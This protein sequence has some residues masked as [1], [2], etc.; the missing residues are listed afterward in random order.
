V[1][2]PA[3]YGE[4]L[5]AAAVYLNVQQWIPED[6]TAQT[7]ADLFGAASLCPASVAEWTRRQAKAFAPVAAEI[8]ALAAP[9]RCAAST[10]PASSA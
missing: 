5:R 4:R 9:R 8:G 2:G 7:L 1:T 6:R 3:Q 10:R